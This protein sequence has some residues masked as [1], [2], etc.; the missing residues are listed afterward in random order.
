MAIDEY[1]LDLLVQL[2]EQ[3]FSR[4]PVDGLRKV[5]CLSYPDLIVDR[6]KL[7]RSVGPE[8]FAKLSGSPQT[9]AIRN[10]H[11]LPQSFDPIYDTDS[12][13]KAWGFAATYFDLAVLRGVETVLDFNE[14]VP[15]AHLLAYD[16]LLDTG[17]LEHC[18]NVGVAFKSV[19]DMVKNGG[20]II[21]MAPATKLNRGFWNFSPTAY[22]DAFSQNGFVIHYLKG[23]TKSETGAGFFDF[24]PDPTLR[25]IL[26]A[27]AVLMCVARKTTDAPFKWPVQSK[28]RESSPQPKAQS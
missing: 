28:Y 17:T 2:V 11:R 1:Y 22:Y 21:S 26:P 18:F 25:G 5:A 10:W 14:P 4:P 15:P 23:R 20:F 13:L 24:L 19:C 3:A 16:L 12:L 8:I 7:L 9:E 6:A 27:E